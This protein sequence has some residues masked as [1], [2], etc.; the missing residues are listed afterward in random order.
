[1]HG[2]IFWQM[3]DFVEAR[4]GRGSWKNLLKMAGLQDQVY[5]SRPYPDSEAVAL[6]T[7]ISTMTS[8]PLPVTLEEFGQFTVPSL[9]TLYGHLIKPEW[10]TLDV[11]EHAE[12]TAHGMVR[13]EQ[14]GSAPPYLRTQRHSPRKVLLFYNSPRKMC[15]FAVGVGMGLGK[16]FQETI[17]VRHRLCMHHGDDQCEIIF[18]TLEPSIQ[19]I[20][21]K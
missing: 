19:A 20:R 4:C 5:L 21:P 18:E 13:R 7:A 15:S 10:R 14:Q 12:G 3:R 8:K 6:L 11:I 2:T 1:M 16:H 9:L 17:I